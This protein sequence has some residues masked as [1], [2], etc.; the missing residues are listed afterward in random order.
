[1]LFLPAEAAMLFALGAAPSIPSLVDIR[2]FAIPAQ[3]IAL[4]AVLGVAEHVRRPTGRP[5]ATASSARRA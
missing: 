1:V 3:A 5:S 2:R 4:V